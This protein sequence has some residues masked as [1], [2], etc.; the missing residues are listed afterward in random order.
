MYQPGTSSFSGVVHIRLTRWWARWAFERDL[1]R[2]F[3]RVVADSVSV[4]EVDGRS[5][6]DVV[7][8]DWGGAVP[9]LVRLLA[10]NGGCGV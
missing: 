3:V 4:S 9:L 8:D 2:K 10:T 6:V 1:L 5:V 7:D